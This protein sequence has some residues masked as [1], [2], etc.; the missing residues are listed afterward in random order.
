MGEQKYHQEP[1]KE[2]SVMNDHPSPRREAANTRRELHSTYFVQNRSSHD[3]MTRLR[4]QDQMLTR[5]MGG[6]LPEQSNP[7]KFEHVLDV[8][9][10]TGG[11]LIEVAKTY[12]STKRL[13][14]IDISKR[15]IDYA[16]EQAK[17]Q[18]VADR[19]EF[20][21]MDA[22]HTLEFQDN[23]FHLVNHRL[24]V[25][26]LR[27]W[28]WPKLLTEYQRVARLYGT[29]RITEAEIGGESSSLANRHLSQ[30]MQQALHK[31]GNFFTP[32]PDGVTS[33]LAALLHQYAGVWDQQMR[34][35]ALRCQ[36]GTPEWQ[37]IYDDARLA[38]R[39][40]LP[41]LR[42]WTQMPDDYE[43]IYQ[44][45]LEQMHQPDFTATWNLLTAWGTKGQP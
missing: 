15:M 24:G 8:G 29:I 14:G 13:V 4:L 19:V 1:C 5:M 45:M 42:K 30:L 36:V 41:F 18:Q 11:W 21:V 31:A 44:Q 9:C 12:P 39:T 22:L 20:A 10:G 16:C 38:F 26:W 33:Q 2:R 6:V 3:E 34:P 35:Y 28:E 27:T 32:E 37:S 40:A 25:G 23:F 43:Q 7:T 17:E